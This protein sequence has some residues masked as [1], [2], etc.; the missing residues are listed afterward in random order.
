MQWLRG[1]SRGPRE[2]ARRAD[3]SSIGRTSRVRTWE[4]CEP[5]TDAHVPWNGSRRATSGR[6]PAGNPSVEGLRVDMG[7][8]PPIRP[9]ARCAHN[10]CY[11]TYAGSRERMRR[12]GGLAESGR[13]PAP[14]PLSASPRPGSVRWTS[15]PDRWDHRIGRAVDR[16]IDG[17]VTSRRWGSVVGFH[18]P[19]GR[20][21]PS[22]AL[23]PPPLGQ[24]G[25]DE[26]MPSCSL[27]A[28]AR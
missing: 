1:Q 14:H 28:V 12:G 7:P 23:T 25:R 9:Y 8:L 15:R 11:V 16:S 24:W 18:C 2:G 6:R 22:W 27:W 19:S 21:I 5:R 4:I 13:L 3:D 10:P 26:Q 20:E 17:F